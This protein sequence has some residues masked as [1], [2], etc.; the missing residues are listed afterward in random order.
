MKALKGIHRA[1]G[2]A[3]LLLAVLFCFGGACA[4]AVSGSFP[5]GGGEWSL[6]EGILTV[7]GSVSSVYD[8]SAGGDGVCPWDEDAGSIT[9]I[10]LSPGAEICAPAEDSYAR[11][12]ADENGFA[13]E[14]G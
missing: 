13:F 10:V 8:A 7:G 1:L 3:A 2:P 4:E 5:D 9:G 11:T 12:W 6:E 14:A